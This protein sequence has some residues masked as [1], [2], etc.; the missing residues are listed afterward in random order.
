MVL[1][2][3]FAFLGSWSGYAILCILRL[4]GIN[5]SDYAIGFAMMFA[6]MGGWNNT[7]IFIFVNPEVT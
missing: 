3:I 7:V 1:L 6:K 2:M 5:S 4:F